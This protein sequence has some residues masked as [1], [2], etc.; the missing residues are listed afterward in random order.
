M[1]L[2]L[3]PAMRRVQA[4]RAALLLDQPFFGV[5]ALGLELRDDPSCKTAWVNGQT[6]GFNPAFVESLSRDALIA[7]VA[8]EVMHCAAGHP[9]RRDARD[10]GNWNIAADHAINTLLREAGFVLPDGALC[11]PAYAGK[12]AE[13]IYDRLPAPPPKPA[14]SSGD[15][16]P[17][18]RQ[19]APDGAQGDDPTP[20][21]GSAQGDVRDAP[22]DSDAPTHDDW[23]A[24][25]Q[26]A[27]ASGRG[28]LPGDL[29]RA[30]TQAATPVQDWRSLLR[31]YA[32]EITRADYTWTRPNVRYLASG[33]YLPSLRS[34]QCGRF[35]IGVDTSGSVDAVLLAQFG[36]E[37]TDI[38]REL[39]PRAID[40]VYCDTRVQHVDT[41][42]AGETI[43]L[44]PHGG[45]GTA[46]A[47]VFEHVAAQD[48]D[49]ELPALLIYFTDLDGPMPDAAPSYPVIWASYGHRQSAP[50]GDV[51]NCG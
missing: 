25:V 26:S 3:S 13:W 40:V 4:A 50:F 18:D 45:G 30:I 43:V 9:W 44:T 31:K 42:A 22:T 51:V 39:Q 29:A 11:D 36:A 27:I 34:P 24:A 10:A 15:S 49:R 7:L 17:D 5:L 38:A 28:T 47:P 46:F 16:A 19:G 48:A 14:P 2:T 21:Q 8:H 1:A 12:A 20:G 32:Q 23:Q 33:I 37:I 41:Y 6:L 35:V